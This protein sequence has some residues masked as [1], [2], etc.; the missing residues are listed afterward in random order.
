MKEAEKLLYKRSN[1]LALKAEQY[2]SA[3]IR[4]HSKEYLLD[5][6][7]KYHNLKLEDCVI[8]AD[9][10]RMVEVIDNYVV[11]RT[12]LIF[13]TPRSTMG[14][15]PFYSSEKILGKWHIKTLWFNMGVLLLMCIITTILLLTDCPGRF[16]RKMDN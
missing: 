1:E 15:A 7:R 9:Q 16:M 5:L 4:K 6:K 14:R 11:P 2:I 8:G 10:K 13:L 12:G 3:F